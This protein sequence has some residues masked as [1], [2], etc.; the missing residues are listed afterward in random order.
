MWPL[1]A[2]TAVL[3]LGGG[4][5]TTGASG[6]GTSGG[7]GALGNIF[8]GHS[9]GDGNSG[10]SLESTACA[11]AQAVASGY[12]QNIFAP[13]GYVEHVCL[14]DYYGLP[15][16]D[17]HKLVA[18]YPDYTLNSHYVVTPRNTFA[19]DISLAD[20]DEVLNSYA[21]VSSYLGECGDMMSMGGGESNEALV[22]LMDAAVGYAQ[23]NREKLLDMVCQIVCGSDC[24]RD[25]DG[26]IQAL[27]GDRQLC[28]P[29]LNIGDQPIRKERQ[30]V[31]DTGDYED[32]CDDLG[33]DFSFESNRMTGDIFFQGVEDIAPE[34]AGE[35]RV[36]GQ[37]LNVDILYHTCLPRVCT[38]D[39]LN[40][41]LGVL[42]N[43]S[44]TFALQKVFALV[45][46]T[47]IFGSESGITEPELVSK[48]LSNVWATEVLTPT[49]ARPSQM[50][51]PLSYTDLGFSRDSLSRLMVSML[52]SSRSSQC[53]PAM[54]QGDWEMN[55]PIN[56]GCLPP[57]VTLVDLYF[58]Y[59][60]VTYATLFNC[61][62][63][64]GCSGHGGL[65]GW[66]P[67]VLV[68][69]FAC[70]CAGCY[71]FCSKRL[72]RAHRANL[73]LVEAFPV[74]ATAVSGGADNNFNPLVSDSR[75]SGG[76][77]GDGGTIVTATALATA[78]ATG[79]STTAIS[80]HVAV[81][82]VETTATVL[83][84]GVTEPDCP[85]PTRG[86]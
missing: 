37:T 23:H 29:L 25:A 16:G 68:L 43:P 17:A 59:S 72:K 1:A 47:L 60:R 73:S 18:G 34:E 30:V 83:H 69:S 49:G 75:E 20:A 45:I 42:S 52:G 27:P 62:S 71:Y 50:Q 64:F 66:M 84:Q 56:P 36:Q 61:R 38:Q 15:M 81:A 85:P 32:A 28:T 6:G 48:V 40:K 51:R 4:Q 12:T 79:T 57:Q 78:T 46:K 9:D 33:D 54:R 24:N 39:Q 80:D 86:R 74:G 3:A 76:G 22:K 70:S 44:T 26:L 58:S 13:S 53:T 63:M 41:A 82:V 77:G 31:L 67:L 14:G 10:S 19:C 7:A 35:Q 2:A 65:Y 55:P 11:C 5:S 8:G 21:Q